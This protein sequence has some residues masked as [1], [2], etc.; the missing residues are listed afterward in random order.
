MPL[1]KPSKSY[2]ISYSKV[3]SIRFVSIRWAVK[4]NFYAYRLEEAE[5]T[6]FVLADERK[7]METDLAETEAVNQTLHDEHQAL[8]IAFASMEEKLKILHVHTLLVFFCMMK[9]TITNF[10]SL[11]WEYWISPTPY[12]IQVSWCWNFKQGEW[13]FCQVLFLEKLLNVKDSCW[14]SFFKLAG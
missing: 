7:R 13:K 9:I 10:C 6:I 3:K 2:L 12:D 11:V 14:V 1:K 4:F 5:H 8:Q